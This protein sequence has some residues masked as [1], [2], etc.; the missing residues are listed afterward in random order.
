[1]LLLAVEERALDLVAV[2][3]LLLPVARRDREFELVGHPLAAALP[4]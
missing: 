3:L 1:M 4:D 2:L